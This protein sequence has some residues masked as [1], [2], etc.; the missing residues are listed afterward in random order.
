MEKNKSADSL[1]AMFV[2]DVL[3]PIRK[4]YPTISK[5][6]FRKFRARG[7]K[8]YKVTGLGVCLRPSEFKRFLEDNAVQE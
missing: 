3:T 6:T 8:S 1:L 5:E 2:Y 7:L 4:L